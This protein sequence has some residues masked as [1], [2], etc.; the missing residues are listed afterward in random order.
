MSS[1]QSR[2]DW[3]LFSLYTRQLRCL[4]LK[5]RPVPGSIY[6]H[7][8]FVKV[9][10]SFVLSQLEQKAF[11]FIGESDMS[12][13]R[14]L[15]LTGTLQL[16]Q[17]PRISAIFTQNND[18]HHPRLF[19]MPLGFGPFVR[20]TLHQVLSAQKLSR[21]RDT[22]HRKLKVL[23]GC[24]TMRRTLHDT[25]DDRN[26]AWRQTKYSSAVDWFWKEDPYC[27]SI[28]SRSDYE[29]VLSP[30]GRGYD[31]FRTFE[32]LAFGAAVLLQDGLYSQGHVNAGL[33]VVTIKS[34]SEIQDSVL[35]TWK[36]RAGHQ[37][38]SRL[39]NHFWWNYMCSIAMTGVRQ[40]DTCRS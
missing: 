30:Y 33:S 1:W 9:F 31:C 28:S 20:T 19:S 36:Q 35:S 29:F 10:I 8:L 37:N 24:M 13:S 4:L 11:L 21:H 40:T 39:T 12:L 34:F 15:G 22:S 23:A 38:F 32:S 14:V 2:F 25:R 6:V 16:L 7:V 18:L 5:Q 17:H 26:N 3:I 27:H